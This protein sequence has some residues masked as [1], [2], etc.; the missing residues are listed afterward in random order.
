MFKTSL[1]SILLQFNQLIVSHTEYQRKYTQLTLARREDFVK[2]LCVWIIFTVH[3][4]HA[5]CSFIGSVRVGLNLGSTLC[6]A[7]MD[8]RNIHVMHLCMWEWIA[9]LV[10]SSQRFNSGL[11]AMRLPKSQNFLPKL[12]NN[13]NYSNWWLSYSLSL[14]GLCSVHTSIFEE[15]ISFENGWVCVCGLMHPLYPS[16]NYIYRFLIVA[17]IITIITIM[18]FEGKNRLLLGLNPCTLY[19]VQV[20]PKR[21]AAFRRP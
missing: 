2:R 11:A 3:F 17:N 20:H 14:W 8:R 6:V 9:Q 13:D 19:N 16:M 21:V 5:R 10:T 4:S 18:I 12:L 7:V 1:I 15:Q